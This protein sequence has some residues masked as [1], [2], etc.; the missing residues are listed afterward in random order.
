MIE[1]LG[2]VNHHEDLTIQGK[3]AAIGDVIEIIT[4]WNNYELAKKY[5]LEVDM[6]TLIIPN[7]FVENGYCIFKLL[8]N[9]ILVGNYS[10]ENKQK[11]IG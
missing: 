3:S 5:T 2:C 8:K 4:F 10:F 7:H 6:P 9:D 1:Y 11:V